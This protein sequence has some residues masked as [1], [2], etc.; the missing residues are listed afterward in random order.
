MELGGAGSVGPGTYG[1]YEDLIYGRQAPPLPRVAPTPKARPSLPRKA[2]APALKLWAFEADAAELHNSATE[3]KLLTAIQTAVE[4]GE[5]D[6]DLDATG[7]FVYPSALEA[8][9]PAA[10]QEAITALDY[11]VAPRHAYL[12]SD[13]ACVGG[14][15]YEN[16]LW[17][18]VFIA[19]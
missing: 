18:R 8:A 3:T 11:D 1:P 4:Q 6:A 9:P 15:V 2:K 12:M 14:V 13:R 5:K 16:V 19:G 10:L 17:V 7:C